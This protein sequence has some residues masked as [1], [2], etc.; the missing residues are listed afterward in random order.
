MKTRRSEQITY[1]INAMHFGER[2]KLEALQLQNLTKSLGRSCTPKGHS[3][4]LVIEQIFRTLC[5]NE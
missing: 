5:M 2:N 4:R 3:Q 1:K